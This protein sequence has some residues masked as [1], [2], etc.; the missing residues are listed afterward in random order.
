[1]LF[2]S[3]LAAWWPPFFGRPERIIQMPPAN[4]TTPV[5]TMPNIEP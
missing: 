5:N 1:M 3:Y 2:P 4:Q